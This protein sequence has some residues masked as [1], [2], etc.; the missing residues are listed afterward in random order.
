MGTFNN[1]HN[2]RSLNQSKGHGMKSKRRLGY[3]RSTTKQ[4]ISFIE[5][6][7]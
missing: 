6:L 5:Q 3:E 4:V 7:F 2:G 1:N